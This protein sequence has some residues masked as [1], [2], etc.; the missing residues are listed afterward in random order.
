MP[1]KPE[2]PPLLPQG[3]HP[4]TIEE[5]EKLCVLEFSDSQLRPEIMAGFKVLYERL[6]QLEVQGELWV[7]GSFLTHKPEPQ[8]IDFIVLVSH[9]DFFAASG[10]RKE[11][12]DWLID[13]E[14]E[15][16]RIFY[17]HTQLVLF[18]EETH[19]QYDS[20]E[21]DK[22]HWRRIYGFSVTTREP[23][24]IAVIRLAAPPK[25]VSTKTPEGVKIETEAPR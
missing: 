25:I 1:H 11:Y 4:K 16:K 24:G 5:L 7:D 19:P 2:Y 3:L 22:A 23:K 15:P 20:L 6:V 12:F 13:N 10:A 17:C 8:D 14:D 18:A 9:A 21:N